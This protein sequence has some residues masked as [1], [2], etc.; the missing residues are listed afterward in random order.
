MVRG[1]PPKIASYSRF[2]PNGKKNILSIGRAG[3]M[4]A[5]N[6]VFLCLLILANSSIPQTS[7]PPINKEDKP[8]VLLS[9]E[10]ANKERGLFSRPSIDPKKYTIR[11]IQVSPGPNGSIQS[12]SN[13]TITNQKFVNEFNFPSI[14]ISVSVA[15]KLLTDDIADITGKLEGKLTTLTELKQM[16]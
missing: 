8:Y 4:K 15:A 5:F 3:K 7:R 1:N 13:E 10:Q 14:H 2:N 16:W 12:L 6:M 11:F 9:D